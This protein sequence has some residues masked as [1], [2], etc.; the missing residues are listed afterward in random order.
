MYVNVENL[1][2]PCIVFRRPARRHHRSHRCHRRRRRRRHLNFR[3]RRSFPPLKINH[4]RIH[5][6]RSL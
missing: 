1:T 2:R 6:K 4:A 3:R 5:F